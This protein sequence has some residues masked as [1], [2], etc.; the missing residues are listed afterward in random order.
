MGVEVLRHAVGE[1]IWGID[2][3]E[4]ELA[5]CEPS[6]NLA[7]PA[8]RRRR[9]PARPARPGRGAGRCRAPAGCRGRP[10]P[11]WRRRARAPR[12]PARRCRCR[13][14][15]RG[16][17]RPDRR[18]PRRSPRGRGRRSGGPSNPA[19]RPGAGPPSSPAITRIA[20]NLAFVLCSPIGDKD[21][22]PIKEG[23]G[24]RRRCRSGGGRRRAAG[25][26]P[27]RR[28]S[29]GGAA[30]PAPRSRA[31][32][33]SGASSGSLATA[34]R[35]RPLWR[36]PRISPSP[37]RP[38]S[39]SA[40]L[41]PSLSSATASSRRRASSPASSANSRHWRRVLAAPDPAAQLVQLGDAEALGTLDHHHR[42]VG[43]VDPD[44][45]HGRRDQHVGLAG[46][47]GAHRLRL[48]G[49][50]HLPVQEA[51]RE[52][53]Q[54]APLAA[55]PPRPRPLCPADFSDS[56]T[57]GQTTKAWRPSRRRSRRNS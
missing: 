1:S 34:K 37:R 45:D 9:G 53:A 52:L 24:R 18:G 57:S 39:I 6:G 51:D 8:A 11:P 25:R 50:G 19:A 44:L 33:S 4:V 55:A 23:S 48:L 56:A 10:G 42:R 43:D 29:R 13:G 15:A 35:G 20:K 3:D 27:G 49:R 41:K 31:A 46:G 28:A 5:R 38:R 47:E 17:R 36:V 16:R 21:E 26:G 14:R 30:A 12:S 40:S 32:I 2:E 7:Q 54:L 22:R